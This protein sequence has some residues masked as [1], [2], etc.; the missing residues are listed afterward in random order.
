[1]STVELQE[2]K[3]PH[4]VFY[5]ASPG[6]WGA[7]PVKFP[8]IGRTGDPAS[9]SPDTIPDNMS[10]SRL[11]LQGKIWCSS[12]DQKMLRLKLKKEKVI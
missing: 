4:S 3:K 2:E 8:E 12:K 6:S 5:C 9:E 10:G 11:V 7:C 1:M